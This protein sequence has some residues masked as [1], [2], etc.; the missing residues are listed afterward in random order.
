M[1]HRLGIATL[2]LTG[3]LCAAPAMAGDQVFRVDLNKSEMLRLPAAAGAIVVGNPLIADISVQDADTLFVVG[4][5]FGETNLIVLDRAGQTIM[6]ADIQVTSVT[7]SHG[8]RVFNATRRQT[9]SCAPYCQPSPILG[10]DSEFIG[11]NSP[12]DGTSSSTG[13]IFEDLMNSV[14]EDT[15]SSVGLTGGNSPSSG[16]QIQTGP[17]Y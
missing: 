9:Y 8:L 3:L 10:D 11:G 2:A 17:V 4:R 15:M 13:T 16:Q 14:T 5:G 7:P 12:D 6:N 1:R